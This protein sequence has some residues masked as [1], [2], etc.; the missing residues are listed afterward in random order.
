MLPT[1]P[2]PVQRISMFIRDLTSELISGS[3]WRHMDATG[4]RAWPIQETKPQ[5]G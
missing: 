5:W 3:A 1:I 4:D 2:K